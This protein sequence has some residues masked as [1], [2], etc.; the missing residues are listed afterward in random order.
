MGAF[1]R[2][3]SVAFGRGL[4][5]TAARVRYQVEGQLRI[6][7]AL[8]EEAW[9]GICPAQPGHKPVARISHRRRKPRSHRC[10]KRTGRGVRV[11]YLVQRGAS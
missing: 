1:D 9:L 8:V 10:A 3:L 7:A 6:E 4:I 5:A 11:R 2:G